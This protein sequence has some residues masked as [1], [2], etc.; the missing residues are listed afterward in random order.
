MIKVRGKVIL[1]MYCPVEFGPFP[2]LI[3]SFHNHYFRKRLI[4]VLQGCARSITWQKN[5]IRSLQ[6]LQ[7]VRFHQILTTTEYSVNY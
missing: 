5:R 7:I 1:L 4:D 6:L 2:A 3:S